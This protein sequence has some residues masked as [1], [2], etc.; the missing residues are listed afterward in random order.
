MRDAFEK[1]LQSVGSDVLTANAV[2]S[3]YRNFE[4]DETQDVIEVT[5]GEGERD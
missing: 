3:R 5:A 2:W 4:L 1:S